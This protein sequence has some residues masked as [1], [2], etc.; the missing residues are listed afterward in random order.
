MSALRLTGHFGERDRAGGRLLADVVAEA[1]ARHGVRSG[2]VLRGSEGFG[3]RHH[4][5]T[6]R[7]LSLSDDLPM[8]A[9]A[10]GEAAVIEAL[11]A[12]LAALHDRGL[13]TLEPAGGPPSPGE[14]ER[15]L[16]LTAGR[17]ERIG[18]RPAHIALV[19]VLREAG[20][21]GATV[22]LGVDGTVDGERRRARF[23]A[24]NGDVPVLVTGIG[25][26]GPVA[27]AAARIG[28]LVPD[29][30]VLVEGACVC[31]RDGTLLTPPPVLDPGGPGGRPRGQRLTVFASEQSRHDGRPLHE[32]LVRGLRAAGAAGATAQRGVWGY[33]GD[34]APH[35]ERLWSVLAPT[36]PCNGVFSLKRFLVRQSM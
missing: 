19:D 17:R 7:L 34:H 28:E 23:L 22:L 24:G 16:S 12:E 35:G 36:Q 1:Y 2:V 30:P 31:K 4:L 20:V 8:T 33:H 14:D 21:Q 6:E 13:L 11:A 3:R 32:S 25:A 9:V 29:R 18:G 15:R 27:A 10:T 26:P 5:Q